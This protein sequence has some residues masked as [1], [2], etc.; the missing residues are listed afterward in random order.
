MTVRGPAVFLFERLVGAALNSINDEGLA[1]LVGA[2][3]ETSQLEFK[4]HLYPK[5]PTGKDEL[6]KDVAALAN[7]GGGVLVLGVADVAGRASKLMGVIVSE[8]EERHIQQVIANQVVPFL[9]VEVVATSESQVGAPRCFVLIVPRSAHAPHAVRPAGDPDALKYP[10]RTG[11]NTDWLSESQVAGLYRNRFAQAQGQAE[12]VDELASEILTPLGNEARVWLVLT[13]VPDIPGS[14]RLSR[15]A[16]RDVEDWYH[17]QP[18]VPFWSRHRPTVNVR[19]GYRRIVFLHDTSPTGNPAGFY[20]H[21][22][23]D[24]SAAIASELVRPDTPVPAF[25][26]DQLVAGVLDVTTMACGHAVENCGAGGDALVRVELFWPHFGR[27]IERFGPGWF[28]SPTRIVTSLPVE[29]VLARDLVALEKAVASPA[30]MVAAAST[31]AG[32]VL[33]HFG[34]PDAVYFDASGAVR[35]NAWHARER[36][37]LQEVAKIHGIPVSDDVL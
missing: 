15:E 5:T 19:A 10:R 24:G 29:K 13:L 17:S 33:Q 32:H 22:H 3:D 21:L 1:R 12:R 34:S 7:A 9:D 26:E 14:L 20:A 35:V 25:Y 36:S 37:P 18:I 16:L 31:L 27:P 4:A 8:S 11:R 23:G 28:A 30:E 6:C 2:A